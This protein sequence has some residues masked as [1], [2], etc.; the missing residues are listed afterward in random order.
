MLSWPRLCLQLS[1]NRSWLC[2]PRVSCSFSF[3][4]AVYHLK[5]KTCNVWFHMALLFAGPLE[6][7]LFISVVPELER[8]QSH[9]VMKTFSYSES[10]NYQPHSEKNEISQKALLNVMF[11]WPR[12]CLQISKNRSWLSLPRVTCSFSLALCRLQNTTF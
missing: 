4:L 5:L 9:G 12:L 8:D 2:L 3:F 6:L 11:S 10:V 7:L 1:K